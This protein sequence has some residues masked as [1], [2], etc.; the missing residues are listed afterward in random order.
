[1]KIPLVNIRNKLKADPSMG[2]TPA[3]IDLFATEKE[4]EEANFSLDVM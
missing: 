3:D 1:M 2:F 4:I